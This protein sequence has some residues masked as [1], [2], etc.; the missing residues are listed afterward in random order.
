[1]RLGL[2][3]L[4]SLLMFPASAAADY[5]ISMPSPG[6]A[7]VATES[8]TGTRGRN[9]DISSFQVVNTG[10]TGVN[11]PRT[12]DFDNSNFDGADPPCQ[13][14]IGDSGRMRCKQAPGSIS[15]T[16]TPLANIIQIF[17]GSAAGAGQAPPLNVTQ[18][19]TGAGNDVIYLSGTG[20]RGPIDGGANSSID[21]DTLRLDFA[22]GSWTVDLGAGTASSSNGVSSPLTLANLEHLVTNRTGGH[23]LSGSGV[24]EEIHAQPSDTR[25][26][27]VVMGSVVD[28]RGGDDDLYGGNGDD[29]MTGGPGADYI[30]CGLGVDTVTDSE[31]EDT[32]HAN[33]E[34]ERADIEVNVTDDDGNATQSAAADRCDIDVDEPGEQCSL[35][36]AMQLANARGGDTIKF[37]IPGEGVP[38]LLVSD[39]TT[40]GGIRYSLP[41][42]TAP[43][44]IDGTTQPGGFV[45]IVGPA[46]SSPDGLANVRGIYVDAGASATGGR[47]TVIR[48]LIVRDFSLG[49]MEVHADG[50]LIEGN[51]LGTD[52]S[53]NARAGTP[54]ENDRAMLEIDGDENEL[55]GNIVAGGSAFDQ[56]Y[57]VAAVFLRGDGNE[58]RGNR[59]GVAAD[60]H[61]FSAPPAPSEQETSKYMGLVVQGAG[62]VIGADPSAGIQGVPTACAGSCNL[63]AGFDVAVSVGGRE[64][65]RY[66]HPRLDATETDLYGNWIGIG[67]DGLPGTSP[68]GTEGIVEDR[69]ANSALPFP[70]DYTAGHRTSMVGNRVVADGRGLVGIDHAQISLNHT[71]SPL[72][73]FDPDRHGANQATIIASGGSRV[74]SNT[75]QSGSFRGIA[76]EEA[77]RDVIA[78]EGVTV[79]ENTVIDNPLGGILVTG[80]KRHVIEDNHVHGNGMF[81]IGVTQI[82][83]TGMAVITHNR[84]YDNAID[85]DL[86]AESVPP[87]ASVPLGAILPNDGVTLNDANDGDSGGNE[88]QNFPELQSVVANGTTVT[89]NGYVDTPL[90][91]GG[92]YRIEGFTS[93]ACGRALRGGQVFGGGEHFAGE[94]KISSTLGFA[95]FELKLADVPATDRVVSLTATRVADD[96]A[97]RPTDLSATS[98]FSQC[99][100]IAGA[101][102]AGRATVEAGMTGAVY[103]SQG[104]RVSIPDSRRA[105]GSAHDAGA[106]YVTRYDAAVAKNVFGA[107]VAGPTAD[108]Y[109]RIADR[110]LTPGGG[111]A[112]GRGATFQ[113]CLDATSV[114]LTRPIVVRR[115]PDTGGV[116]TPYRTARD[117][118]YL[119]AAGAT[120]LGEFTIATGTTND[121][122]IPGGSTPAKASLKAIGKR[123]KVRKGKALLQVT[124]GEGARCKGKIA[125]RAKLGGKKHKAIGNAAFSI[126]AAKSQVVKVKLS[127]GA[128]RALRKKPLKATASATAGASR[129]SR[130]VRLSRAR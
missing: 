35:R 70:R 98:E 81:G 101:G 88:L 120:A 12:D 108:R 25:D 8:P 49:S 63:I 1:M 114:T 32:I 93:A 50:A 41:K 47:R 92:E 4:T 64:F 11:M 66:D 53:G 68:Q 69:N 115:G 90:V 19:S 18:I 106:L 16:G 7:F 20:A 100:L 9:I 22:S 128:K 127:R 60:G 52:A 30:Y 28:G 117:G 34:T 10:E 23:T 71:S 80:G 57:N 26:T 21:G 74:T 67:A 85:I 33:C 99:V 118:Q 87:V 91:G 77:E 14:I 72:T 38:K 59:V 2:A 124:C 78:E 112:G 123:A 121:Y 79:A 56:Y 125:L 43:T 48:G 65:F 84:V 107:G 104:A 109:W 54:I 105:A 116:W 13:V 15:I 86:W 62:N 83:E 129:L 110:G 103:D 3:L 37:K 29:T 24:A 97:F 130:T 51:R 102:Q 96:I 45:E 5:T 6:A 113:V 111:A 76:I 39:S 122:V 31:P 82:V 17:A 119:C 73:G 58:M 36:A 46:V 95:D 75:V 94:M 44:T 61:A 126:P 27:T 89:V 55:V 42:L 40:E